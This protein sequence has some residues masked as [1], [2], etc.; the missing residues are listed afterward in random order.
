M[1][2][3]SVRPPTRRASHFP[4]A[5]ADRRRAYSAW[6]CASL[7]AGSSFVLADPCLSVRRALDRRDDVEIASKTGVH[8][9]SVEIADNDAEREQRADVPQ[10]AAGRAAAC[11]S[12]SI[13]SSRSAS[14]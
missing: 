5:V 2:V 11:C 4:I 8:V 9:F 10:G 3:R 13:A 1:A 14:G 6:P 7:P 12:I